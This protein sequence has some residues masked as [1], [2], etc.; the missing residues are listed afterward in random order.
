[1]LHIDNCII[2]LDFNRIIIILKMSYYEYVY[3]LFNIIYTI[4][5]VTATCFACECTFLYRT[6]AAP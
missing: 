6:V 2:F 3:L 4:N 5:R 1:M